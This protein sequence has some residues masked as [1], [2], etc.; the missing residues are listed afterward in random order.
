MRAMRSKFA[1]RLS[2]FAYD[3][4]LYAEADGLV[5]YKQILEEV[6]RTFT[7]D[8]GSNSRDSKIKSGNST[9]PKEISTKQEGAISLE[10]QFGN[11]TEK[12]LSK[13][14]IETVATQPNPNLLD[15]EN[16]DLG[17]S[18]GKASTNELEVSLIESDILDPEERR[19]KI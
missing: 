17:S 18:K 6:G 7:A 19:K 3:K 1:R 9:E 14:Q 5:N 12:L 8:M 11:T 13:Y 2:S 15:V 10:I 4:D 16:P